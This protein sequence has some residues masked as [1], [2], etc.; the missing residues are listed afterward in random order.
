MK[1]FLVRFHL[2]LSFPSN[3]PRRRAPSTLPL[4]SLTAAVSRPVWLA[5]LVPALSAA[6]PEGGSSCRLTSATAISA[7]LCSTVSP[8]LNPDCPGTAA[9]P[10][11]RFCSA[12]QSQPNRRRRCP[13][14]S[15]VL[16]TQLPAADAVSKALSTVDR[17]CAASALESSSSLAVFL[18]L[19]TLPPWLESGVLWSVEPVACSA[20][21]GW[22]QAADGISK[23]LS[24]GARVVS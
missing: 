4:L 10:S 9:E 22:W 6:F 3:L 21:E 11:L 17:P 12:S 7:A 24:V 23:R 14:L 8:L 19:A 18:A 2:S 13:C 15:P 1:C 5:V 20:A 16:I